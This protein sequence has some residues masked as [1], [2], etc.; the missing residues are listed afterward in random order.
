MED[1]LTHVFWGLFIVCLASVFL[2]DRDKRARAKKLEDATAEAALR[3]M[4][5]DTPQ[6]QIER[7]Q[8]APAD[9]SVVPTDDKPTDAR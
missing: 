1:F 3:R 9:A 4:R 5:A 8:L 6:T 2:Y 7:A